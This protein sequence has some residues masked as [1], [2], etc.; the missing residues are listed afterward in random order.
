MDGKQTAKLTNCETTAGLLGGVSIFSASMRESGA[1]L[2]ITDSK[3]TTTGATMPG[4]WFGNPIID[5]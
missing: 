4:L 3:M 2:K 5:Y 1:V